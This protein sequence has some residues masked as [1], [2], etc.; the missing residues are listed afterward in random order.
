MI[1]CGIDPGQKGGWATIR[2]N[3]DVEV[4]SMPPELSSPMYFFAGYLNGLRMA[5]GTEELHVFIEKAQAMPKQGVSSMF[6]YGVHFG[7]LL[8]II[9]AYRVKHTLVPP[10]TWA[11]KIHAGTKAGDPKHRTL[12]AVRRLFPAV[13]LLETPRCKKP[14]SGKVD[15]LAIAEYGRRVMMGGE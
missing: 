1:I 15:A 4:F 8:G 10:R 12:E 6:T 2:A 14:H 11:S 7:T 9:M 13:D 5:A 3:G